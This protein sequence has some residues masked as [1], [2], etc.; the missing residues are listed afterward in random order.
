MSQ[1]PPGGKPAESWEPAALAAS[2]RPR[3]YTLREPEQRAPADF[4]VP[5][6]RV[7]MS[8]RA[9]G[10]GLVLLVDDSQTAREMYSEYLNHRGFWT[11][12]APDGE[13][14]IPI[15]LQLK[16]DVIVMDLAMPRLDGVSAIRRLKQSA[17]TRRIPVILL[18]GYAMQA[19]QQGAMEA[20]ADVFLTKPCLPEDLEQHVQRLI[21][22]QPG[23]RS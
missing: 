12:T 6:T 8:A 20:G 19:I 3:G 21:G 23:S 4:G 18:T 17:R 2:P 22:R 9:R 15:A 10:A 16:P 7:R 13:A 1:P 11:V 5:Q 14:S